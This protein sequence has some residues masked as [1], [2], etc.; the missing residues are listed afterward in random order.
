M[1]KTSEPVKN[2]KNYFILVYTHAFAWVEP[3]STSLFVEFM[4]GFI[5]ATLAKTWLFPEVEIIQTISLVPR[6]FSTG[7]TA[8]IGRRPS[9]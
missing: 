5:L 1:I 9:V 8:G 3:F 7:K 6:L 4:I 2:R